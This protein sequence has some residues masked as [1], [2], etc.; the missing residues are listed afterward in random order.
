MLFIPAL[1][2]HHTEA[3]HGPSIAVNVFW[4]ELRKDQYPSKDLYGNADPICATEAL[5]LCQAAAQKLSTLPPDH[6]AFYGG[7]C[8]ISQIQ[9]LCSH[10]RL[11]LSFIYLRR[12]GVAFVAGLAGGRAGRVDGRGCVFETREH[13]R[14]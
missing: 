7:T 12:R 8:C 9:R 13:S 10:T 11:T 5:V 2:A 14:E 3:L 1:W 6:K 4:R